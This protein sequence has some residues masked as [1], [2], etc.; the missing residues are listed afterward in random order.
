MNKTIASK[1]QPSPLLVVAYSKAR[2]HQ[3][4][5]IRG[6]H[7]VTLK[8]NVSKALLHSA[9]WQVMERKQAIHNRRCNSAA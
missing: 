5:S 9:A 7:V 1:P 6:Q 4:C 8:D 3:T 2:Q